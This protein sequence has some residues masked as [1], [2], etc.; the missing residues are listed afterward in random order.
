[1][2]LEKIYKV[3]L[4]TFPNGKKYCGFT[5]KKLE[6]RWDNGNGYQKCPL[7]YK[8]IQKY[9]WDNVKK[10]LLYEFETEE[11]GLNKE[12]EI[13]KKLQLTNPE[14]GYNLH[15]GGRPHGGAAFLTEEGRKKISEAS[16]KRWADPEFRQKMSEKAKLHPPSKLCRERAKIAS[17]KAHK[18]VTPNNARPID[19]LDPK[20][21]ELI[22]S[23]P[24]ACHASVALTGNKE[25]CANILKVCKGQR[26]SA[27]GWKW[28]FSKNDEQTFS[29]RSKFKNKWLCDI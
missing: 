7:V 21:L 6:R 10:E 16:K 5:S 23:Y 11:E 15:E 8:A 13:I 24:S 25:G 2:A 9:G 28:R 14:Y 12:K 20:T 27:Y 26:Y 4:F 22:T 29:I 19:Q 17:A 18:G 1:M 3:Y